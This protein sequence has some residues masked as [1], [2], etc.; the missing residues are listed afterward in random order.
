[1]PTD[2]NCS[3]SLF[4][5]QTQNLR[6]LVLQPCYSNTM[7]V[8]GLL[9]GKKISTF[10]RR[11]RQWRAL[12]PASK[13]SSAE[14]QTG[15]THKTATAADT[16]QNKL[17]LAPGNFNKM[18]SKFP[19]SLK[20]LTC[21]VPKLKF[22]FLMFAFCFL[23]FPPKEIGEEGSISAAARAEPIQTISPICSGCAAV[24]MHTPE[25]HHAC[26]E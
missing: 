2:R 12:T 9:R 4:H 25:N 1:M 20:G 6:D 11:S 18:P 5:W 13:D 26:K 3:N 16:Y 15:N 14:A 23:F 8:G 7:N 17:Y 21:C 24:C 19:F 22:D 10:L